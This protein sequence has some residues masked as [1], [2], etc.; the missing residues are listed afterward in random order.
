MYLS[1]FMLL[2]CVDDAKLLFPMQ[3]DVISSCRVVG[4]WKQ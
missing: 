3:N 4:H 1:M 2:V